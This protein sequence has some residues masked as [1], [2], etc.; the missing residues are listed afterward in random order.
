MHIHAVSPSNNVAP[1]PLQETN[2]ENRQA[3]LCTSTGPYRTLLS[4][5][6]KRGGAAAAGLLGLL[7]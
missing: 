1:R 5:H 7:W 4:P 2:E 6:A 3:Y